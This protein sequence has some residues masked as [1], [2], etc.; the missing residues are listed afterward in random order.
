[1]AFTTSEY[2][3]MQISTL[4]HKSTRSPSGRPQSKPRCT[5]QE[6]AP[7]T[8][9]MMTTYHMRWYRNSSTSTKC[10]T[11]PRL[12]VPNRRTRVTAC[13][14]PARILT[15]RATEAPLAT[16]HPDPSCTRRTQLV[17]GRRH[18][19]WQEWT[20]ACEDAPTLPI[21][22]LGAPHLQTARQFS[23]DARCPP[24]EDLRKPGPY[25]MLIS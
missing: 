16:W 17:K 11:L 25:P 22:R 6:G 1:M 15:L 4:F 9:S 5:I 23:T 13:S 10:P 20:M 2:R 3:I 12:R 8:A 21:S 19:M 18:R 14:H 7:R 24:P